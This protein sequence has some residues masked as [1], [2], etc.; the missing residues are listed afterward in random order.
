ML[1]VT[2]T[3][4]DWKLLFLPLSLSCLAEPERLQLHMDLIR[5]ALP[6]HS[7]RDFLFSE[8]SLDCDHAESYRCTLINAALSC[9]A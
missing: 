6:H 3:G 1:M 7:H 2:S 5:P 9:N 4:S 8:V